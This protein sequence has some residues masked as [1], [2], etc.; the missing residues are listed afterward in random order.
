MSGTI[1]ASFFRGLKLTTPSVEFVSL[2]DIAE[3]IRSVSAETKDGLP[4]LKLAVMDGGAR[5]EH[6]KALTGAMADYDA[7]SVSV[8]DAANLLRS[9]GVSALIY[10]S[11]NSTAESPRWRVL[12]P[13]SREVDPVEHQELT[14]RLNGALRGVIDD[15]ASWEIQQRFYFG[16]AKRR[17]AKKG[18]GPADPVQ[19]IIVEG[20]CIDNLNIAPAARPTRV[21]AVRETGSDLSDLLEDDDLLA[22]FRNEPMDLTQGEIDDILAHI[23]NNGA[24]V[25]YD[26]Y[27]Q[28][29]M[30]L[31][32]QFCGTNEGFER[33]CE[34]AKQS[35]KFDARN[36][37][38]RWRSFGKSATPVRMATLMQI[39]NVNKLSAEIDFDLDDG[40]DR[41]CVDLSDILGEEF[42]TGQAQA[43]TK[44]PTYDPNWKQLLDLVSDG[45]KKGSIKHTMPNVRL[46]LENDP[47]TRGVLGYNDF[48]HEIVLT[49]EPGRATRSRERPKP[50]RQLEGPVWT[51]IDPKRGK[52]WTDIH[53]SAARE[54]FELPP[55]QGGYGIKISDRDLRSAVS[56]IARKNSFHPVRDMLMGLP[57]W[58]GQSRMDFL[59]TDYLG[60]DDTAYHRAASRLT[61]LGAVA[62]VFEPGCKF[63]QVPIL[64]GPQGIRKSTFIYVLSCGHFAELEGDL[65]D[66]RAMVEKMEGA[67]VVEI[68]EMQ[69]F[70]KADTNT[71]KGLISAQF[72]KV[73]M[74]Y[75]HRPEIFYRQCIFIGSTNDDEILRDPTGARRFW[76]IKCN[77]VSIDIDRLKREIAQIYAEAVH[78]YMA[79]RK[80]TPEGDLPLYLT[81]ATAAKEASEIQA[82]QT[83]ETAYQALAAEI[84]PWLDLPI[85]SEDGFDDLDTDAPKTYR[86]ETCIAQIW[87]EMM[88]RT[89]PITDR[90]SMLIGRAMKELGWV[91]SPG[92]VQNHEI[93]KK[94]GRTRIYTR[95]QD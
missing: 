3:R 72:D 20:D 28:V 23:P 47:R 53:D 94:Y 46:I 31:H 50:L 51:D 11:P 21:K 70:S 86:N 85:E 59:Y 39:A 37:A 56:I 52:L 54:L 7:G 75:A 48:T 32:H 71:V 17:D 78:V 16:Q 36:A 24:G 91:R 22:D 2:D 82:S 12:A 88:G 41:T 13:Y 65:Q 90:D 77:T 69:G 76:P 66:R 63:D 89:T 61:L 68:P 33:W 49:R 26:D 93:N 95:P 60:A 4:M 84:A 79:M 6:V 74:A 29:G 10:T 58:D 15:A 27:V 62:R 40:F 35:S 8:E 80:G 67:W 55:S 18:G 38:Q 57:A 44:A 45:D 81:D 87:K 9:A 14:D 19:I 43:D 30:A 73:R 34:W 42:P 83:A 64:M 25:H 1:R 92:P 5:R